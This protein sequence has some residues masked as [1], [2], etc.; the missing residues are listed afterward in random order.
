MKPLICFSSLMAA[1]PL[2]KG[3]LTLE[4]SAHIGGSP[5]SH[6][7]IP[8]SSVGR[9]ERTNGRRRRSL[10][11]EGRP[12][13]EGARRPRLAAV[14]TEGEDHEK[15]QA[16]EVGGQRS[17]LPGNEEEVKWV[18]KTPHLRGRREGGER[19]WEAEV[20]EGTPVWVYF[21]S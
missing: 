18:K 16:H 17:E 11:P 10:R 21:P 4:L 14:G 15:E 7:S 1:T 6:P 20:S 2:P 5:F 12:W 13:K 9:E 3:L 8:P 19:G